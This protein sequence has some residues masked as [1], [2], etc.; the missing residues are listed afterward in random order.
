MY[1]CVGV[2]IYLYIFTYMYMY[3][4]AYISARDLAMAKMARSRSVHM[5][6]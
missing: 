2:H 6:I 3:I 5:C 1:I 4:C